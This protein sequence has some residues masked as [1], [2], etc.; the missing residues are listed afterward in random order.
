MNKNH[1]MNLP[2]IKTLIFAAVVIALF[3]GCKSGEM[4]DQILLMSRNQTLITSRNDSLVRLLNTIKVEYDTLVAVYNDLGG[5]NKTLESKLSSLQA[6]YTA[7]AAE[8]KKAAAQNAEITALFTIQGSANDSL[9]NEILILRNRVS[10]VE[11]ALAETRQDNSGLMAVVQE[12]Q[13][14]IKAD[15]IAEVVRKNTPVI[16]TSGF[17]N[18]SQ[19]GGGFGLGITS[20]DYNRNLVSFGN[21]FGYRINKH[22]LTGAGIG[23]HFYNGGTLIPLWLDAR[24]NLKSIGNGPFISADGGLMINPTDP[25]TTG[26]FISPAIGYSKPLGKRNSLNISLGGLSMMT[27][28]GDRSSFVF[29]NGGFSFTGKKGPEF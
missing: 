5:E 17:V 8:L 4:E 14:K 27:P 9:M 21:I 20:T 22:F 25:G 3:K 12:K 24:Y 2:G 13:E 29:I 10:E 6:R 26:P 28:M 16:R 18:I 7:R 19:L 11:N 23:V 1:R 15:S